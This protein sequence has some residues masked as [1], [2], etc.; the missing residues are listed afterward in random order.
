M[1][2]VE[3]RSNIK[4]G[5]A[6]L[7]EG[8]A[9]MDTKDIELFLKEVANILSQKKKQPVSKSSQEQLLIKKIKK[10]Y[11][12]KLNKAYHA[13]SSKLEAGEKLT[14]QEKVK[15]TTITNQFEAL[16]AERLQYLLELAAS[17]GQSLEQLLIE[18][19]SLTSITKTSA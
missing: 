19:P 9:K 18:M 3:I 17:R 2:E 12:A 10:A 5:M 11:P 14:H 6:D 15:L 4:L 7:L 8:I 16:D 13:L 1:A